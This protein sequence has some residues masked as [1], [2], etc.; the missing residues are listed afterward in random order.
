MASPDDPP[1]K[2]ESDLR[3]MLEQAR[4]DVLEGRTVPLKPVMERMRS[5]AEEIRRERVAASAIAPSRA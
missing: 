5:A 3:A 1:P 4:H 2:R